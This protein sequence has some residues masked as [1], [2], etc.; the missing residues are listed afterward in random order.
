MYAAA[1]RIPLSGMQYPYGLH[2][3]QDRGQITVSRLVAAV[4]V[5][6]LRVE[7]RDLSLVGG[8]RILTAVFNAVLCYCKQPLIVQISIDIEPIFGLDS[9][10]TLAFIQSKFCDR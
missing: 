2:Q 10:I 6:D 4:H 1:W 9:G 7:I 3:V 8:F 5:K